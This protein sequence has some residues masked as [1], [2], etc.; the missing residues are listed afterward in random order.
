MLAK[1]RIAGSDF[2]KN[3]NTSEIQHLQQYPMLTLLQKS[4]VAISSH[5]YNSHFKNPHCVMTLCVQSQPA[6]TSDRK[7]LLSDIDTPARKADCLMYGDIIP[8]GRVFGFLR[9]RVQGMLSVQPTE[10]EAC[11]DKDLVCIWAAAKAQHE[12]R[13]CFSRASTS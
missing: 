5:S 6:L 13:Q 11:G 2:T 9:F 3:D 8:Q 12:P 1:I 10:F 7:V 4:L